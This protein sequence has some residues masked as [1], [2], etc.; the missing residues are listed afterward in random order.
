MKKMLDAI[1]WVAVTTSRPWVDLRSVSN[2]SAAKAT[3]F[4]PLIGYLLI[5]NDNIVRY[6]ELAQVLNGSSGHGGVSSRLL[7]IYFGLCFVSFGAVLYGLSC[8][9]EVKKYGSAN[10][11]V[12]GDRN[13]ISSAVLAGIEQRLKNSDFG[14]RYLLLEENKKSEGGLLESEDHKNTLLHMYFDY[15]NTRHR[16]VRIAVTWAYFVGFSCLAVP[17]LEVF[18]RILRLA[19]E[20]MFA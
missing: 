20:R 10:A 14:Q 8:P 6:L 19:A 18:I 15:M 3:I 11:Y 7:W 2:S 12:A 17:S 16:R 13:S 1:H 5:F 4:V 9:P